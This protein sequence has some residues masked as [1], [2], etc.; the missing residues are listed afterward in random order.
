[1]KNIKRMIFEEPKK[2]SELFLERHPNSAIWI[3]II[4]LISSCIQLIVITFLS[5]A[6]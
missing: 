5:L 6:K 3:S 2:D 1:M 4:A